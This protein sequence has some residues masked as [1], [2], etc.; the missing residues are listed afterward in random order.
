VNTGALTA[1]AVAVS[2]VT[3]GAAAAGNNFIS[4][5]FIGAGDGSQIPLTFIP[6]GYGIK[7]TDTDDVTNLNVPFPNLPIAGVVTPTQLINWPTDTGLQTW[8]E[9]NISDATGGKFV[10]DSTY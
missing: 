7:V 3:A 10:F 6:D 8:I 9:N 2:R 5:S 1:G 4:G